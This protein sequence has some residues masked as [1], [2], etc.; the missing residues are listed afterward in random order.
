MNDPKNIATEKE[1]RQAHTEKLNRAAGILILIFL[2][3]FL[4]I[5]GFASEIRF[6]KNIT[7]PNTSSPV[8]P[9]ASNAS[10]FTAYG[11]YFLIS[12]IFTVLG[13]GLIFVYFKTG[14]ATSIFLSLFI[15]SM[16]ML[17]SPILQ[18]FWYNVFIKGFIDIDPS[19]FQDTL[20]TSFNYTNIFID[21]YNMKFSMIN[22]ISQLVMITGLIGR[23]S[24]FQI[25]LTSVLY[26]LAWNLN[27]FLCIQVQRQ[28]PD[29]KTFDD[30]QINSVYLFAACFGLMMMCFLKT[31]PST[32]P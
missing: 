15:V 12:A 29:V 31:P 19:T 11:F 27:L 26:N 18:K 20:Y 9:Q 28:S 6:I 30:Y 16:T 32:D 25:S 17:L 3:G 23:L 13:F 24:V 8:N 2:V 22:A 5:Y 4:W 1:S 10:E 7:L 21:F 14:T